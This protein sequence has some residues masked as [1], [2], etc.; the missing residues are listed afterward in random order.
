[1]T[2]DLPPILLGAL[3]GLVIGSFAATAAVR[4]PKGRSAFVGRSAC[5]GCGRTL[6]PKDLIPLLSYVLAHGKCRTCSAQI[7]PIHIQIEIAAA[8]IGAFSAALLPPLPALAA[9][10][11]GWTL[12]TLAAL[13]LRH[14]WLPD[15]IVLPLGLAGLAVNAADIGPGLTTALIGGASGFVILYAVGAIYFALRKRRGLGGGDP[16]LL[17]AIGAWVGWAP[18]PFVML[19]AASLGIV[20]LLL[21]RLRG[22]VVTAVT[23]VPFGALL[24]AAAW[25]TLIAIL[26]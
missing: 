22:G 13:D 9:A 18:L 1:M 2:G 10:L 23:R 21:D 25:P 12:L 17:G 11:F 14:F 24:A 6:G 20:L 7:D 4:M 3:L 8:L 16:K 19:G 26:R 15:R 5:D